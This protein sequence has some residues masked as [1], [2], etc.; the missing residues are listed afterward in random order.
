[1]NESLPFRDRW[2][3]ARV[4]RGSGGWAADWGVAIS[5]PLL[6]VVAADVIKLCL[7][8][9]SNFTGHGLLET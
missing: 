1:M 9:T 5:L 7:Q 3:G 4:G 8:Q 6:L 2:V